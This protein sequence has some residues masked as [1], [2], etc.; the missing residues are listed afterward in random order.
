MSLISLLKK[1]KNKSL[2]TTPSHDGELCI[3]HKFYQWYRNDISEVDVYNP[4]E[5]LFDAE[6]RAG[7]IY[8]TKSTHFLINGSTSGII[9]SVLTCVKNGEKILIWENAHKCHKNAAILAGA[10]IIEYKLS[11]NDDWGIYNSIT[12]MKVESLLNEYNPKANRF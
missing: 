11:F 4:Q 8:K 2:Y 5:A 7:I 10:N 12:P 1:S 3:M 9:A 6:K